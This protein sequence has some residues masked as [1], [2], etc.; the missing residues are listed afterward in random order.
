MSSY[1][2]YSVI[3]KQTLT[4]AISSFVC[5]ILPYDSPEIWKYFLAYSGNS[6]KNNVKKA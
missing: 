4:V 3:G 5:A 2:R 1:T 6:S